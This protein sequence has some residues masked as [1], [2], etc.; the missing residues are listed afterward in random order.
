MSENFFD[1]AVGVSLPFVK[2]VHVRNRKSVVFYIGY[3]EH[4]LQFYAQKHHN[5]SHSVII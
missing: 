3:N 5:C 2:F 1:V 4:L